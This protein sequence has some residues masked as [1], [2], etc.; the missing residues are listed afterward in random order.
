MPNKYPKITVVTP[1]FNQ[2][3]Y[4]EQTITSILDQGYPNLEYIVIDGGSTD[5]SVEIIQK[6]GHFLTF[7]VSEKDKGLYDA[8]QKGFEKS[9]GEI[10]CWINSDDMHHRRSLFTI[11]ELFKDFPKVNWIMGKNTYYDEEG[12][13]FV[14]GSNF[15]NERWSKWKM[16]DQDGQYIQQESVFWRRS[17]W[18]KS[19]SYID[20]T[21]SLAADAEL[22]A[23]FF[24]HDQLYST[25]LLLSGF[26]FRSGNQKSKD[27]RAEYIAEL[28]AV[29]QRELQ[30][31]NAK[32]HLLFIR[33][34]K[35][36][37]KLIPIRK[38][39]YKLVMK[40][41]AVPPRIV[42]NPDGKYRFSW[43]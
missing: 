29:I 12:R 14:Y 22:W 30:M 43:K 20:T 11:A 16:Y 2:G 38:I 1:S 26:R 24:R 27:Q 32:T 35:Y 17:L 6:Y 13:A 28:R 34:M 37:A 3:A 23:R 33:L 9:T 31:G 15:F 7:W 19:G 36:A 5:N 41:M 40:V 18:D 39:K 42:Y 21:F 10:M 25:E 4:L 8:L